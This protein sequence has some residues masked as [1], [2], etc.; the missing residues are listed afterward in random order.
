MTEEQTGQPPEKLAEEL[1]EE[2]GETED[3]AEELAQR[4]MDRR[5]QVLAVTLALLV[6]A[7][8]FAGW[9]GWQWFSTDTD[10]SVNYAQ[11]RDAALTDG[12]ANLAVLTSMDYQNVD[13]RIERWKQASTGALRDRLTGENKDSKV[14]IEEGGAVADATVHSAGLTE[15]DAHSGTATMI[16]AVRTEM[17]NQG[18]S[19][20]TKRNR[21]RAG[22]RRTDQGWKL[23]TL[24]PIALPGT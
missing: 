19:A 15:L 16:A 22:L 14:A 1:A 3:S 11:A 17:D 20:A 6:A 12:K 23:S 18:S 5:R 9:S 21:F 10:D 4:P 13:K 7:A 8:G 2:P 24:T